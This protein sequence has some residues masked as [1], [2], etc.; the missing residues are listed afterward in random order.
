MKKLVLLLTC[1]GYFALQSNAQEQT[2]NYQ[3]AMELYND[4]KYKDAAEYFTKE[5]EQNP[6][7]AGYCYVMLSGIYFA[8]ELYSDAL[9]YANLSIKSIPKRDKGYQAIAY[10]C[11]GL[12]YRY[13]EDTTNAISDFNKAIDLNDQ[14]SYAYNQLGQLYRDKQDYR[15]AEDCFEK[16]IEI[17]KTDADAYYGLGVVYATQKKYKKAIEQFNYVIKLEP[18]GTNAYCLRARAYLEQKDYYKATDD[19]LDALDIDVNDCAYQTMLSLETEPMQIMKTK[20]TVKSNKYPN[21]TSYL[22]YLGVIANVESKYKRAIDYFQKAYNIDARDGFLSAISDSYS[23]LGDYSQALKYIEEAISMDNTDNSYIL[24]KASI[25]ND[26]GRNNNAIKTISKYI[27][28]YPE[29]FFGY[30]RRGWFKEEIKDIDGA[31]EDYTVAI[32]LNPKY[33]YSYGCRGKMYLNKGNEI[34]AK[35]DFRKVI[36][37]EQELGTKYSG[38][39]FTMF[40]YFYLGQNKKAKEVLDS[41]LKHNGEAEYYDA[42][43]LYSLMNER[44]NALNYLEKAFKSGYR[45]F[46]HIEKDSDLDNIRNEARFKALINKYKA[47][48]NKENKNDDE[49]LSEYTEKTTEVPFAREGRV[50]KVKCKIN[51]LPLNMIFDTGASDVSISSVE[52]TFMYK[53]GYIDRKDII[54]TQYFM[55]ANGEISEGTIINLK[56][57]SLEDITV[58]NI[59]ASVVSNQNAPLLLGQTVLERFGK[60]EI[61]NNKKVLKITRKEKK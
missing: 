18:E 38:Y 45:N 28:A 61:D 60:I 26:M 44:L 4:G 59:R 49:D 9:T 16:M 2:Y 46:A 22:Y 11:R 56:K 14:Y 6:V 35:K 41:V 23:A 27:E 34:L 25:L 58:N 39:G 21:N 12:A 19:I 33:S 24:K 50:C 51:N 17:D 1:I 47:I 7:N 52:A 15:W 5:I 29:Y 43:C 10:A 32:T 13:L 37:L 40:A 54:G 42:A 31:I 30:H 8:N 48:A 57:V 3:R 55:N 20:L 53:N 36:E